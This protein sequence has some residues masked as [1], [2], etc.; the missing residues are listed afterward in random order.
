MNSMR[1][2][3]HM[4]KKVGKSCDTEVDR[5]YFRS[6]CDMLNLSLF[7]KAVLLFEYGLEVDDYI[8][9]FRYVKWNLRSGD[10]VDKKRDPLL[11]IKTSHKQLQITCTLFPLG[12]LR[13]KFSTLLYIGILRSK[14][15]M[16]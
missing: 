16:E 1:V 4:I 11:S 6:F 15:I 3:G 2:N 12:F 10:L 8:P 7:H 5:F 9:D 13:L 14:S